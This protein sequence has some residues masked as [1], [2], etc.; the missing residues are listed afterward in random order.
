MWSRTPGGQARD[1]MKANLSSLAL[2]VDWQVL[3]WATTGAGRCLLLDIGAGFPPQ[4][5]QFTY[6]HPHHHTCVHIFAQNFTL[7]V[8]KS[9]LVK[10]DL[11]Q[12]VIDIWLTLRIG[13][14]PWDSWDYQNC[15]EYQSIINHLQRMYLKDAVITDNDKHHYQQSINQSNN[16]NV[17]IKQI[18]FEH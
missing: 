6:S 17:S 18:L 11:Y 5:H 14:A 1:W 13:M 4:C 15:N 16:L 9:L 8:T 7:F 12:Y 10:I 3:L 2:F